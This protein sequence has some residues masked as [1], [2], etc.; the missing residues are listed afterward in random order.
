MSETTSTA[1]SEGTSNPIYSYRASEELD[2]DSWGTLVRAVDGISSL[3]LLK[4]RFTEWENEY[5]GATALPLP[6]AWRSAKSVII[7]AGKAGVPIATEYGVPRGKTAVENAI[8]A[9]TTPTEVDPSEKFDKML[10]TLVTFAN[11]NELDWI[12]RVTE[13]MD[14]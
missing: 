8:K 7:R 6:N 1:S 2:T 9:G 5:R 10:D 4:Q 14:L 11:K 3:D 13:K 12:A